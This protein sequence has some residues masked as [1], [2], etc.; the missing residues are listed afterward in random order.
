MSENNSELL[1]SGSIPS[2]SKYIPLRISEVIS[3]SINL[4]GKN[5]VLLLTISSIV[6]IPITIITIISKLQWQSTILVNFITSWFVS[7]LALGALVWAISQLYLQG[8]PGI[9]GSF[10]AIAKRYGSV[11]LASAITNSITIIPSYFI[12][13]LTAYYKEYPFC[14]CG[15]IIIYIPLIF[16][17]FPRLIS[18]TPS[19]L[20][21]K[22]G[23]IQGI[24]RSWS[25][26]S[27]NYWRIICVL[28]IT[29]LL[30]GVILV[31]PIM[32]LTAGLKLFIAN[33][34][35]V[36]EII[37]TCITII[38]IP[39]SACMNVVLFY[40]LRSNNRNN[41]IASIS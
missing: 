23:P 6:Y 22:L 39:L 28:L 20:I 34:I 38:A 27:G 31:F 24:K 33:A 36:S 14:L 32:V 12:N 9:Y 16:Y 17:I 35:I 11:W 3:R 30:F 29:S 8:K 2:D 15:F 4:F 7:I 5:L 37:T 40:D 21:E 10:Q 1:Q 41:D 25:L 19:I 26:S 18:V 13:G